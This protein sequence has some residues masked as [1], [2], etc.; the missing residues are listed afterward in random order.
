M[1]ELN[2]V[3]NDELPEY[4]SATG[5]DEAHHWEPGHPGFPANMPDVSCHL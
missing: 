3:V 2:L 1:A 5:Q 4:S